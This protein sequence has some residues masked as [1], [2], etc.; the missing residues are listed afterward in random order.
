MKN[1]LLLISAIFVFGSACSKSTP[2]GST[3]E[4]LAP[5]SDY[6][7]SELFQELNKNIGKRELIKAVYEGDKKA[8]V[9]LINAGANINETIGTEQNRITPLLTA[10]ILENTEIA[11]LLIQFD[12]DLSV[13]YQG[14]KALEYAVAAQMQDIVRLIQEKNSYRK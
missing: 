2:S 12:A 8:V 6:S 1:T 14:Y 9:E 7:K 11:R 4:H 10:I 3:G 13:T 5:S